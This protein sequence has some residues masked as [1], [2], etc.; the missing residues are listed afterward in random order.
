MTSSS[1]K[2]NK[3]LSQLSSLRHSGIATEGGLCQ[4]AGFCLP[5]LKTVEVLGTFSMQPNTG[6]LFHH[7]ALC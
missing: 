7:T 5:L 3:Q 1:M 6:I 2:Q 4:E